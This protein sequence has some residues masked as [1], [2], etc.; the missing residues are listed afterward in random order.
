MNSSQSSPNPRE[1]WGYLFQ[2][3]NCAAKLQKKQQTVA[4]FIWKTQ[5]RMK[6]RQLY[7][8]LPPFISILWL[9]L[10]LH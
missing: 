1:N 2:T 9:G 10:W 8:E 3:I 7:I 5:N 6:Q 4:T